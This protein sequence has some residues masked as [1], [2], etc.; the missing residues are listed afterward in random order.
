VI[1]VDLRELT[2]N[3]AKTELVYW[4]D[5]YLKILD[6]ELLRVEPDGGKKAYLILGSTIFH[7]KSGGQPSDT[8]RITAEPDFSLDVKKVMIVDDVVAH[9]GSV[10]G[11]DIKKLQ[12][13]TK[14]RSEISWDE[15]YVAMR[16]HTAGHLFDH[17]LEVATGRPSKT[18]DS[19][20][21]EPCYVTYEGEMPNKGAVNRALQLEAEGIRKGLSVRVEFVTYQRMLEIA[22][23]APNVARLPKSELMRIVTIDGCKPIPC[24]GTHLKNTSEIGKFEY[25]KAENTPDGKSFKVYYEVG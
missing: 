6:T 3:L 9:Y 1:E 14:V 22:G 25:R 23:D 17:C 2:K 4:R 20:L 12:A 21:G 16:R 7:P 15:R 11:G 18:V 13:G 5:S 24:G 19:W 8:G 10:T